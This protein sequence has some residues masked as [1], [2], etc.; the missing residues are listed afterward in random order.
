[1]NNHNTNSIPIYRQDGKVV[2]RVQNG[3]LI[4]HAKQIKLLVEN[5]IGWAWD[6]TCIEQAEKVSATQIQIIHDETELVFSATFS[7][8]HRFGIRLHQ[9][10]RFQ[11]C[12]PMN[13]WQVNIW[14]KHL[15]IQ[16]NIL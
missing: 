2:G 9:K 5:P 15:P 14:D 6:D 11:T 7:D 3:V 12:L 1:M 4:V 8:I 13:Y 10:S 16:V